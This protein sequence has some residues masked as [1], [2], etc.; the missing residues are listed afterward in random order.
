VRNSRE[1]VRYYTKKSHTKFFFKKGTLT[2]SSFFGKKLDMGLFCII[3]NGLSRILHFAEPQ[4][5]LSRIVQNSRE[6]VRYYT[7]KS[8]TKFFFK[9]QE[10]C[11]PLEFQLEKSSGGVFLSSKKFQGI[12]PQTL[13]RICSGMKFFFLEIQE[14]L[15]SEG[16]LFC[17]KSWNGVFLYNIERTLE[18]FALGVRA[19]SEVPHS[20][21]FSRVRSI[22]YKKVPYQVFF[23]KRYPYRV[24][25]F[26][27]KT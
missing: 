25:L 4:S 17:K 24:Q 9:S 13:Q 11:S 6:S 19:H 1:S 3:S 22:L 10:F 15:H 21:K 27:K 7:K 2:E 16:H 5:V 18:N 8:H 20:A 26:W 14:L 23:Q 12:L